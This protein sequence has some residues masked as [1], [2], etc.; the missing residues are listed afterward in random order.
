MG[1]ET[2]FYALCHSKVQAPG[3]AECYIPVRRHY[4]N[5]NLCTIGSVRAVCA[6]IPLTF[7]A[8]LPSWSPL[9]TIS[10]QK[11]LAL[12]VPAFCWSY[13]H[14]AK[15]RGISWTGKLLVVMWWTVVDD[16][17]VIWIG[18]NLRLALSFRVRLW[19]PCGGF[20]SSIECICRWAPA[21]YSN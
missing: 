1:R 4:C 18:P 14:L 9:N 11:S 17:A 19:C 7:L 10:T 3:H 20:R 16:R 13:N 21:W 2:H 8:T 6:S 5:S 12:I 15:E